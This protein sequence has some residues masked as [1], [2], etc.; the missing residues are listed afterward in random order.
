M[1]GK[2]QSRIGEQKIDII[3]RGTE[4]E[5]KTIHRAALETGVQLK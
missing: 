3:A 4:D 2:L 1:N 5:M